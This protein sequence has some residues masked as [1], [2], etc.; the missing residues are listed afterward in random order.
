MQERMNIARL[1]LEKQK[2]ACTIAQ[3]KFAAGLIREVEALQMEVDLSASE[4]SFDMAKVDFL[5]QVGSFKQNLGLSL[6]DSIVVSSEFTI[7]PV[8]VNVEK[9]V[10]LALNNRPEIRENAIRIEMQEMNI[11]RQRAQGMPSGSILLDYNFIGVGKDPRTVTMGGT[12]DQTWQNLTS[13]PGSFG[14]GLT[15]SIPIVDWGENKA[16]V[17]SAI[18][19]LK[20]DQLQMEDNK[21]T[22]ERDIRTQVDRLQSSL[23]RLQ[24][25]EKS[26]VVAEKSFD[27][28]RQ[29]YANGEIDSQS[30]ALERERLNGAYNT[31]LDAYISYKLLLSDLMRKTFYDFEKDKAVL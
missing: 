30:M 23:R 20:Q 7:K 4:N 25:L 2:E 11:K 31:R 6:K 21:M 13:R 10:D 5:S 28:S 29:R 9:A 18:A 8:A 22:I 3:S 14:V 24:L 1:S 15:A 17:Q 27:I 19:S 12:F 26:M 16:R